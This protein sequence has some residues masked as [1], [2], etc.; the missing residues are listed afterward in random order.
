MGLLAEKGYQVGVGHDEQQCEDDKSSQRQQ[1]FQADFSRGNR[2]QRVGRTA[3]LNKPFVAGEDCLRGENDRLQYI[4]ADARK[5][6]GK[7]HQQ[8]KSGSHQ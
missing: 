1:E 4:R 8:R 7:G 3:V 5:G 6:H 2:A